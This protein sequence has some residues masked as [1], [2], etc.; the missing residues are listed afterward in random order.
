L[1]LLLHATLTYA[2]VFFLRMDV[3]VLTAGK[4]DVPIVSLASQHIYSVFLKRG[5]K[6]YD[7][8][9][10]YINHTDA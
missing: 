3:R 8:M 4:S 9:P 6:M 1:I 2:F 7:H 5:V 10:A